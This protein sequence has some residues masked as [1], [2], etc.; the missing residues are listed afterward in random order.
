MLS[1]AHFLQFLAVVF[2]LP[3]LAQSFSSE[4]NEE[5]EEEREKTPPPKNHLCDY[6]RCRHLQVPCE[7][8]QGP[9]GTACLCPALSSSHKPPEPPRLG[10]VHIWAEQGRAVVH[11]C[12]PSS[13]VDEYWLELWEGAWLGPMEYWGEGRRETPPWSCARVGASRE[14]T[15]CA[16]HCC[17][18]A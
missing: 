2:I 7:E 13:P 17:H 15:G 6:D 1:S 11:W 3:H 12:A 16:H 9:N 10:E 5:E 18:C 14:L 8:L 4:D